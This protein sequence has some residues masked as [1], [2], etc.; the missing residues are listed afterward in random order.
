MTVDYTPEEMMIVETSRRIPDGTV[1]FVGVGRPTLAAGL[2][3]TTRTP[4]VVLVFE[5]GA[6]GAKP[7]RPPHSIADGE[8][9]ETADM[10]V[11]TP[12]M[13]AYWLGGG[14][15][16]VGILGT[17]QIDPYGNLNSTIVGPSYEHP[18]VRLPGA[19]GAPEIATAA[20][21]TFVLA[22]HQRR[23]FVSNSTSVPR[24]VMEMPGGVGSGSA[25]R[26]LVCSWW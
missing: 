9:A 23:V 2:A 18:K 5:S 13:F 8:L 20:H 15:I 14:K 25:Y 3:R 12:E 19:G 16:D 21:T 10:V 22:P 11:P 24:S 7:T 1:C 26:E 4:N 17:A 6:I